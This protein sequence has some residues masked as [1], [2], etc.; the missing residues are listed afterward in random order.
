[1]NIADEAV[2]RVIALADAGAASGDGRAVE[3]YIETLPIDHQAELVALMWIGR[4][5]GAARGLAWTKVVAKAKATVNQPSH[6]LA[7][8]Q[9]AEHLRNGLR[10][11]IETTQPP[12][13]KTSTSRPA[14]D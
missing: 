5:D 7:D 4:H 9:L 10:L 12:V 14:A 6:Y 11:L 3:A 1:M 13:K 2:E 8:K